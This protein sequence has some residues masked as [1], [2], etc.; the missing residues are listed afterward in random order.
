MRQHPHADLI[1]R[2]VLT[3]LRKFKGDRLA[4]LEDL[5][6]AYVDLLEN[7]V[8]LVNA[9]GRARRKSTKAHGKRPPLSRET[10]A[11]IGESARQETQRI[12]AR[13]GGAK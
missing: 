10:L 7:H 8:E 11:D 5:A 13:L 1:A 3:R 4:A 2:E 6:C 9:I 12:L